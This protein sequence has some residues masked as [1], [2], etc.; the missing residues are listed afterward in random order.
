MDLRKGILSSSGRAKLEEKL[1]L[2]RDVLENWLQKRVKLAEFATDKNKLELEVLDVHV[3][4]QQRKRCQTRAALPLQRSAPGMSPSS[5]C[6]LRL[7][8]LASQTSCEKTSPALGVRVSRSPAAPTCL[9]SKTC[10]LTFR[11]LSPA[12]TRSLTATCKEQTMKTATMP[13]TFCNNDKT[14][15]L[16]LRLVVLLQGIH[17]TSSSLFS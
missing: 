11:S 7:Q 3:P 13:T 9:S 16:L 2:N 5:P 6:T 17:G 12:A 15:L 14:I 4:N 8:H 1:A 10:N